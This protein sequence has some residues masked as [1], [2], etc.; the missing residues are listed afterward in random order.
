VN[1]LDL[2]QDGGS[3]II[4]ASQPMKATTHTSAKSARPTLQVFLNTGPA[5]MSMLQSGS[6]HTGRTALSVCARAAARRFDEQGGD[7]LLINVTHG[8]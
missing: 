5:T 2:E 4:Q 7:G 8:P 1:D 6:A 3:N